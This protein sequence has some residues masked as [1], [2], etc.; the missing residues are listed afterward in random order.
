[1]IFQ[2]KQDILKR[3]NIF[4]QEPG[5]EQPS[6]EWYTVLPLIGWFLPATKAQV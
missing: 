2:K 4:V 6:P 5:F 3:K 1:M